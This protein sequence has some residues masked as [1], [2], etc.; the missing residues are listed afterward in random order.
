MNAGASFGVF[1]DIEDE[2]YQ[3]ALLAGIPLFQLIW[4]KK[5]HFNDIVSGPFNVKVVSRDRGEGGNVT[6]MQQR[7]RQFIVTWLTDG[8]AHITFERQ[9][10]VKNVA[11]AWMPDDQWWHNRVILMDNR[12]ILNMV[13]QL[14][15]PNND[16]KTSA[17]IGMEINCLE[18]FL[19]E[20]QPIWTIFAN[21]REIDHFSKKKDA[22]DWIKEV[23]L[24]APVVGAG[25]VLI[26]PPKNHKKKAYRYEKGCKLEYRPEIKEL[27]EKE[28][29]RHR[30]GWTECSRFRDEIVP[31]TIEMIKRKRPQMEKVVK[32]KLDIDNIS[33]EDLMKLREKILSKKE[34]KVEVVT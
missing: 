5:A 10:K 24:V 8:R 31:Q 23:Q 16:I 3:N 14:R 6:Q 7:Q 2:K 4:P 19:K 11:I 17:E 15:L 12:W 27:I 29:F 20:E 13:S 9:K 30:Y 25:G 1:P 26:A 32:P 22:E 28:K 33:E 21:N 18:S 34:E